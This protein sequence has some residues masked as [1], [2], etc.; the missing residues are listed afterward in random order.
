MFLDSGLD[1]G[2]C[3]NNPSALGLGAPLSTCCVTAL[4]H[5]RHTLADQ[6]KDGNRQLWSLPSLLLSLLQGYNRAAWGWRSR[7]AGF[8]PGFQGEV[9]GG[10]PPEAKGRAARR[11]GQLAT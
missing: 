11:V 1:S 10:G 9:G 5:L 8:P 3:K 7:R 6:G 4:Q 2:G